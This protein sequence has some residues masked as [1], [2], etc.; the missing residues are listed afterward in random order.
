VKI[1]P[2]GT[3]A[4]II[5]DAV[6]ADGSMMHWEFTTKEDGKDAPITGNSPFGDTV[7]RTRINPTTAQSID[8]KGG[9]V[10]A[11]QTAVISADG[12]TRTLTTKGV[13]AAGQPVNSVGVY[14]R[15]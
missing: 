1:E 15:Q 10:T 4:K 2:V 12:K 3:G 5:V 9:K 13:N 14:D 6:Q 8:K 11:T 7:A